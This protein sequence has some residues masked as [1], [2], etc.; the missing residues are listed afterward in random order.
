[1]V[2][3]TCLA[4]CHCGVTG[5]ASPVASGP[6]GR[7]RHLPPPAAPPAVQAPAAG[8]AQGRPGCSCDSRDCGLSQRKARF[9]PSEIQ[10]E[11]TRLLELCWHHR[12]PVGPSRGTQTSP[13]SQLSLLPPLPESPFY[14]LVE[15]SG[16]KAEHDAEKL[17]SFL[18]QL[19]GSGLVTDGTLATDQRK[20]KVCAPLPIAP[21]CPLP[22]LREGVVCRTGVRAWPDAGPPP[23]LAGRASREP[24]SGVQL[25][26]GSARS[27]RRRRGCGSAQC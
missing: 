7:V 17:S 20:I 6:C 1:M 21:L 4:L 8:A 22:R 3:S 27:R 24:G 18:E 26:L 25:A 23:R 16:S 11:Q 9:K 15:T 19:L 13:D 2:R 14:V 5:A 10:P 12:P